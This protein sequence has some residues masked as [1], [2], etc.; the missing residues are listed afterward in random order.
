MACAPSKDSDQPGPSLNLRFLD[1]D[2]EY[3]DQRSDWAD[4]QADLNLRWA[5]MLFCW[6]CGEAALMIVTCFLSQ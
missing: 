1:A 3:S 4:A 2:S 5:H 6:F